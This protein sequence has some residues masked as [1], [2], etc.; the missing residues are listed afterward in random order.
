MKYFT[1]DLHLGEG[2]ALKF[3]MRLQYNQETWA[4]E[5]LEKINTKVGKNDYLYILGDFS[6][7]DAA[8]FR[9]R[10]NC[11]NIMLIVGNHDASEY[12]L[13]KIFGMHYVRLTYMAS[14]HNVNTW[15]SHY[16]HLAW[17]KSHSGAY[18]LYGHMHNQRSEFWANIFPEMR[19]LDVSPE[20]YQAIYG[21]F[22]IFSEN[23]VHEL[24]SQ[25]K[26]HDDI[27]WYR[28]TYGDIKN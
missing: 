18:H 7:K 11:K 10:I 25:K 9:Q 4:N 27:S 19:A 6:E 3:P 16:P 2:R 24:L 28:E 20:S 14:I 8:K 12:N 26:G 22:N 23:E 17:P 5:I 21:H 1:S 15:L 13:Q